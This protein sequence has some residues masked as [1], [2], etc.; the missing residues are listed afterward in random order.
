MSRL[1]VL[2]NGAF[3]RD[4]R[5]KASIANIVAASF[6]DVV[7]RLSFEFERRDT[8]YFLED[9]RGEVLSVCLP[10]PG[11]RPP[12]HRG[13]AAKARQRVPGGVILPV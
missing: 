4:E 5:L 2:R 11:C 7:G 3:R 1:H 8:I 13:G 12:R 9:K 6:D 10:P